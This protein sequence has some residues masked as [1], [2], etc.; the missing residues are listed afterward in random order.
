MLCFREGGVAG[1]LRGFMIS[2]QLPPKF[3]TTF[4]KQNPKLGLQMWF[5]ISGAA[6]AASR[7]CRLVLHNR[8]FGAQ[9]REI[10][11]LFGLLR[12]AAVKS[13]TTFVHQ[14]LQLFHK[15]GL[16]FSGRASEHCSR[17]P[18]TP[19]SF[20][21]GFRISQPRKESNTDKY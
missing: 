21:S 15:C 6:A 8:D 4:V 5:Q 19:P 1:I 12:G 2:R 17:D 18:T 7:T 3:E 13:E 20:Q 9:I 10:E 11:V 16:R 14:I